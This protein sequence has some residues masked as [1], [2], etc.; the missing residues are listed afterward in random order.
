MIYSIYIYIHFIG[1]QQECN[2]DKK[3]G[4]I[5]TKPDKTKLN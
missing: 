1:T 3:S 5:K 2:P 4:N